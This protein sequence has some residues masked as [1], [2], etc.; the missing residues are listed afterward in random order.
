VK[1]TRHVLD[2]DP[3]S[4]ELVEALLRAGRTAGD[5]LLCTQ[6]PRPLARCETQSRLNRESRLRWHALPVERRRQVGSEE[7][8]EMT[9]FWLNMPAA[10]VFVGDPGVAGSQPPRPAPGVSGGAG[11]GPAAP[12]G[13]QVVPVRRRS[14][15]L[16]GV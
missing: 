10:L 5:P 11:F 9:W 4:V 8:T 7:G 14:E 3:V 2:A 13:P 15:Q 12:A 16:V 6:V 1:A